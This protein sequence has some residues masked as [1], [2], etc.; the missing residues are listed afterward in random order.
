MCRARGR[1]DTGLLGY[2]W[3]VG[4]WA[5]SGR[6]DLWVVPRLVVHSDL[7]AGREHALLL[8]ALGR[9]LPLRALRQ[10]LH[11]SENRPAAAGNR[12]DCCWAAKS[13]PTGMQSC[14]ARRGLRLHRLRRGARPARARPGAGCSSPCGILTRPSLRGILLACPPCGILLACLPHDI[15]I[16]VRVGLSLLAHLWRRRVPV[17]LLSQVRD[18][19]HL[20]KQGEGWQG[21]G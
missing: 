12:N 2:F 10:R 15:F 20:E 6:T 5:P 16:V 13:G 4:L 8:A 9:P 21:R 17:E 11:R 1:C 19:R 3:R 7:L 18:D 14:P